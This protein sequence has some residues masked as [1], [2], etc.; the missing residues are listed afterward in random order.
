MAAAA[1]I[2]NWQD[3]D[4]SQQIKINKTILHPGEV[5]GTHALTMLA[6]FL[7]PGRASGNAR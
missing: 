3:T 4:K 7:P 5:R 6:G 2:M 1:E